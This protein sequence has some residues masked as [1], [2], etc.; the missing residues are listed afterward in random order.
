MS[1][2]KI[3]LTAL[4]EQKARGFQRIVAGDELWFFLYYPRDSF[5][6]TLHDELPRCIEQH[7]DAEKCLVSILWSVNGIHCL[8]LAKGTVSNR[9]FFTD[10]VILNLIENVRYGLEGR[11]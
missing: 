9:A 7:N 5:W 10:T 6:A 3:L 8:F 4:M 2:S 1:Y 11:R